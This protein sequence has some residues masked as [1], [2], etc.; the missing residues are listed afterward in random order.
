MRK[1]LTPRLLRKKTIEIYV[2]KISERPSLYYAKHFDPFFFWTLLL[3]L[4]ENMYIPI[5]LN[6][7]ANFNDIVCQTYLNAV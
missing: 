5:K 7:T 1:N 3:A 2:W 6:N 4:L